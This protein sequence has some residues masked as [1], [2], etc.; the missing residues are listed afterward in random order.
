MQN[1]CSVLH[2]PNRSTIQL[3]IQSVFNLVF[4]P[5]FGISIPMGMNLGEYS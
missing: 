1:S 2:S 4:Q 5:M 3:E